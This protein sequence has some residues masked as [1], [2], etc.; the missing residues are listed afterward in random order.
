MNLQFEN[1]RRKYTQA[2][3]ILPLA[4]LVTYFKLN[5]NTN[6][7]T[8]TVTP[9]S[10]GISYVNNIYSGDPNGS[11]EINSNS[12]NIIVDDNNIHT[13]SEDIGGGV[14]EDIPFTIHGSFKAFNIGILS[15][16][17]Y[18]KFIVHKRSVSGGDS[19]ANREWQININRYELISV[20]EFTVFDE[21]S[22]GFRRFF[23]ST[24]LLNST[25]YHFTLSFDGANYKLYLNGSEETL[26][27]ISSG[28]YE[29]MKNTNSKLKIGSNS[30]DQN[31]YLQSHLNTIGIWKGVA[32]TG[33]QIE[34]VRSVEEAGN[35]I[36]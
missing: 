31:F 21:S 34:Y 23:G 24:E 29:S 13:F 36:I 2:G 30:W 11:A 32:L 19:Q 22:G 6:D 9:S 25:N 33:N 35:Y 16:S 10:V 17:Y 15:S 8:G 20:L 5:G 4:N 3:V 18:A 14:I 27:D 12:D 7:A 28:T 26:T 1:M